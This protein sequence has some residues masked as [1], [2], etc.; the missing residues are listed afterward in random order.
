MNFSLAVSAPSWRP[1]KPSPPLWSCPAVA[2]ACCRSIARSRMVRACAHRH[3][4]GVCAGRVCLIDS[5]ASELTPCAHALVFLTRPRLVSPLARP[6]G[7]VSCA[8][9][10][11][12]ALRRRDALAAGEEVSLRRRRPAADVDGGQQPDSADFGRGVDQNS[13]VHAV[14]RSKQ[15]VTVQPIFQSRARSRWARFRCLDLRVQAASRA[16]QLITRTIAMRELELDREA[17]VGRTFC[18]V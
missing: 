18:C 16:R 15:I 3:M 10:A 9:C 2:A 11:M 13:D 6:L 8:R 17:K 7:Q 4:C 14:N 5:E 12:R 1:K